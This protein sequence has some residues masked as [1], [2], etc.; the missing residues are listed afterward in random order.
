VRAALFQFMQTIFDTIVFS[1]IVYKTATIAAASGPLYH[2]AA[3]RRQ[4]I[5]SVIASQ[6]V[7]YYG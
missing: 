1:L 6:G 7:V 5:V 3:D 4:N 2:T